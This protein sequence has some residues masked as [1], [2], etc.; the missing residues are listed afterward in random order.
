MKFEPYFRLLKEDWLCQR[1][2]T[3]HQFVLGQQAP[4]AAACSCPSAA[5]LSS[6]DLP[7]GRASRS[8]GCHQ[9]SSRLKK[10]ESSQKQKK[11]SA[12]YFSTVCPVPFAARLSVCHHW[13]LCP[14]NWEPFPLTLRREGKN[15]RDWDL[16][17]SMYRKEVGW[18]QNSQRHLPWPLDVR[19]RYP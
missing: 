6:L 14:G 17:L 11:S 10:P 12:R 9:F 8:S 7:A 5:R 1:C 4:K 3:K 13:Q 19:G 16:C 18:C 15:V 2:L